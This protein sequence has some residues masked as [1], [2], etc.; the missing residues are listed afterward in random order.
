MS[1]N[2]LNIGKFALDKN[3]I[4]FKV[5][6]SSPLLS[7]L[8]NNMDGVCDY[9]EKAKGLGMTLSKCVHLCR[10]DFGKTAE[11][12]YKIENDIYGECNLRS[13][14]KYQ[15]TY[16]IKQSTICDYYRYGP[17][18]I[19]NVKEIELPFPAIMV[20]L[21]LDVEESEKQSMAF[22]ICKRDDDKI[23]V[24]AVI[25]GEVH[26]Y[27]IYFDSM[28]ALFSDKVFE[29]GLDDLDRYYL[30]WAWYVVL[31]LAVFN[32][33]HDIKLTRQ[34]KLEGRNGVKAKA[35]DYYFVD[36]ASE[37]IVHTSAEKEGI[38]GPWSAL[39]VDGLIPPDKRKEEIILQNGV[40]KS[41]RKHLVSGHYRTYWTGKGRKKPIRRFIEPFER[42]GRLD[43][44][45]VPRVKIYD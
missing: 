9:E 37:I 2:I 33:C 17:I 21:H 3:S 44:R 22:I 29:Y 23:D 39:S 34:I 11:D 27:P 28:G 8:I 42:G 20:V 30:S 43:E 10:R 1:E 14:T 24:S 35:S 4:A 25:D 12:T 16:V 41:P 32:R 5:I 38:S 36:E 15:M 45:M 18:M 19:P 6:E 7:K 40:H 26:Y 31:F 13:W